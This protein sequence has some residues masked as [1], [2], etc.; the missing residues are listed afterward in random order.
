MVSVAVAAVAV[1]LLA[2]CSAA[3]SGRSAAPVGADD[4]SPAL[5]ASVGAH[6]AAASVTATFR[7]GGGETFRVELD[8]PDLV[9]HVRRLLAGEGGPTVPI[10]AVVRDDPGPNAPWSWHL[11]PDTVE[12]ASSAVDACDGTPSEVEGGFL[13]AQ[14]YCPRAAELVAVDDVP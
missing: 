10:G 5:A 1:V 3:P 14:D 11:D 13:D 7:V 4:L 8:R 12:F 2:A 9:E 6:V